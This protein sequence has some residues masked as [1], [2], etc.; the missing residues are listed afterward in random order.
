VLEFGFIS[1]GS[2]ENIVFETA[3]FDSAVGEGHLSVTV[4]NTR[5]PFS[6]IDRA[7]GPEHLTIAVSFIV[8][9]VSLIDIS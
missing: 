8:I 3:L 9:V 4:L 7:I 5:P 1:L 6:L 2:K